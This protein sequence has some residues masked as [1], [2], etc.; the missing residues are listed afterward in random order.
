MKRKMIASIGLML[1]LGISSNVHTQ[2]TYVNDYQK[3][4]RYSGNP[5]NF[6]LNSENRSIVKNN[7]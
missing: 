3:Y 6:K 2:N 4:Y 7:R 1:C 5:S